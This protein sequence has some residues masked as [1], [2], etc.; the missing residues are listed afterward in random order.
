VAGWIDIDRDVADLVVDHVRRTQPDFTFAAMLGIDKTSHAFGQPSP[1]MEESLQLVDATAARIRADAERD[2]RWSTMHLWVTSDHGHSPVKTHEDLA[3]LVASWGFRTVAHPWVFT[4]R[5]EVAVMVSG[6]AMAHVYVDVGAQQ[7]TYWS[8]M[9]DRFRSLVDRL[10]ERPSV[11]LVI[12]PHGS[13]A[14]IRSHDRGDAEIS[15][16]GDRLSYYRGM[17]GDPLGLGRDVRDA[18]ADETYDLTL[19]TDYPDS[20]LQIARLASAPRSGEIILSASRNWDFRSKHE[21]IPHVSAHGALHREH[22][23]VPLLSSRRYSGTPH[24]TTDVMP[25][26]LAALGRA[27]PDGLDGRSFI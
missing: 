12:L 6:N 13:G 16:R 20:I 24:R 2:G 14:T 21:P 27:V 3:G 7:R 1:L 19:A 17:G 8:N 23:L 11:D 22:M 26:A 25:S 18:T 9:S 15:T 4:P 5:P 10:M